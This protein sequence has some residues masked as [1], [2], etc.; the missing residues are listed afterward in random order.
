MHRVLPVL[1]AFLLASFGFVAA[2]NAAQDKPKD[3]EYKITQE[4]IDRK[5]PVKSTPESLT[6]GRKVYGFD[7]AMC[8]GEQGDGKGDLVESM[9]L[10]MHDWRDPASLAGET[11]GEIRYIII[12]GKG[13]MPG[14]ENRLPD[15]MCW[16]LVNVVRDLAKKGGPEKPSSETPKP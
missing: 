1:C 16:N 10:K 2:K 7:C 8:H 5:N 12:K 11:D 6:A 14:E 13:K 15:N 3:S 9:K 4:D